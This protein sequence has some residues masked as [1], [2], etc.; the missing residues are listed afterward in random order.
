MLPQTQKCFSMSFPRT[1]RQKK[2]QW[3]IVEIFAEG[4]EIGGGIDVCEK[5]SEKYFTAVVSF[6]RVSKC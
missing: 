4:I 1:V 5:P 2:I 3:K 6:L